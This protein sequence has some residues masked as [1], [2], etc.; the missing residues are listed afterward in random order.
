MYENNVRYS[1]TRTVDALRSAP[2]LYRV[3]FIYRFVILH[4]GGIRPAKPARSGR[5][6]RVCTYTNQVDRWE[7]RTCTEVV[8]LRF[9]HATTY[10]FDACAAVCTLV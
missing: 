7:K 3:L 8:Y 4:G 2:L 5:L 1:D 9:I 6:T 10:A